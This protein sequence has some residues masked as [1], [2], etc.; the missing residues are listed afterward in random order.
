M[1]F[2][3]CEQLMPVLRG[4]LALSIGISAC[5]NSTEPE[6]LVGTYQLIQI[7]EFSLPIR[8]GDVNGCVEANPAV[9]SGFLDLRPSGEFHIDIRL[10]DIRC[11]GSTSGTFDVSGDAI[12]L[13]HPTGT[14]LSGTIDGRSIR[15]VGRWMVATRDGQPVTM[16][17][18]K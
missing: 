17:Y 16:L 13:H 8:I 15:T 14:E 9:L 11:S 12:T 4:S 6:D 18:R 7:N 5:S 3:Q 2:K 10:S 1:P